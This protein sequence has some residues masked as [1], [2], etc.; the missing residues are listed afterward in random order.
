MNRLPDD[1][2][3]LTYD[4]I[5]AAMDVHRILGPGLLESVYEDA[6][7]VELHMRDLVFERQKQ[8]SI[9]YKGRSVGIMRLDLLVE[10]S[11]I[12]ELKAV[13]RLMPI[14]QAQAMTYLKITGK[15]LALLINFNVTVLKKGIKRIVL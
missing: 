8:I 9:D 7:C 2:N 4:I 6:M 5:G 14:H 1:I 11:V 10:D 13:E 3:N 15:R 12:V